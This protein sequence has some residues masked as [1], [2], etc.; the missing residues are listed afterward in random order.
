MQYVLR[1]I[2]RRRWL[3]HPDVEIA[4]GA[5]Q[6]DALTDLR[7]TDNK[8]SV[9]LVDGEPREL[10]RL[11]AALG[12]AKDKADKI[13]YALVPLSAVTD[14]GIQVVDVPGNTPDAVVN[15]SHR[16]LEQ[17][18]IDQTLDLARLIASVGN[19]RKTLNEVKGIVA[20]SLRDGNLNLTPGAWFADLIA[21]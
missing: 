5:I 8:L 21:Q 9:W 17:L 3:R 19:S 13:D 10:T 2:S 18:T 20:A 14:A 6:A 4:P 15:A 1:M 11:L 12:S 16:N 7:S